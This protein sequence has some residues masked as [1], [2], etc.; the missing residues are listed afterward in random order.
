M[1][2]EKASSV[3]SLEICKMSEATFYR[4]LREYRLLQKKIVCS[5][6]SKGTPFAKDIEQLKSASIAK[7]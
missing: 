2:K 6:L 1:G 3:G 7:E 4:K 5:E